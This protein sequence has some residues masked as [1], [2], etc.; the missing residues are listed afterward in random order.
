MLDLGANVDSPAYLLMQFAV[1]GSILVKYL[2]DKP[3]PSIGLLNIG[4]E[5]I[6]GNEIVKEAN[7]LMRNSKLNFMGY[8]EGD[9]IYTGDVDVIVC[10]GFD[11]NVSLKT[12]EGL[13]QFITRL[14]RQEF[15]SNIL[16][17]VAGLAAIPVINRFRRRIDYRR[18]NGAAFVG[19]NGIVIKSHGG[20]DVLAFHQAVSEAVQQVQHQVPENIRTELAML[21]Q[22]A[23]A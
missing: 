3:R 6:K 15:N 1:M 4:V 22:R 16:T 7:R 12:S 9:A 11:G 18:Y 2:E 20:A 14:M 23:P 13:S 19:L 21:M 17:R 5:D 8:V 10:D